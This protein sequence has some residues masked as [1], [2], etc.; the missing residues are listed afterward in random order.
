MSP[1]WRTDTAWF[2]VAIVMSI[3]AVGNILFGRFEE[4]RPRWRRLLKLPVTLAIVLLL[5]TRLGREWAYGLLALPAIAAVWVHGIW[6]P[7]H[8]ISGWTGEPRR[9]YLALMRTNHKG[10]HSAGAR[11]AWQ[12]WWRNTGAMRATQA[13]R[14]RSGT[15]RAGRPAR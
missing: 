5:A 9:R 11:V 3:F 4:H 1:L 8:G 10:G 12:Q 14:R 7:R 15:V 2:D 6:L 13:R